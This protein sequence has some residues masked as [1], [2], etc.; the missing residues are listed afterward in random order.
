MK[1][2]TA[3]FYSVLSRKSSSKFSIGWSSCLIV[4]LSIKQE[5]HGK[6]S[7]AEVEEGIAKLQDDGII[8]S[9]M[10]ES[11]TL[12]IYDPVGI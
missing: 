11:M 4:F 3:S 8:Y 2:L 12:E 5:I 1:V 6:M 9:T 7:D 10:N